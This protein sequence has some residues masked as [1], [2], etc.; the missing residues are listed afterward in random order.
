L[1]LA[2]LS[3][4]AEAARAAQEIGTLAERIDLLVNNAGGPAS[5]RRTTIDGFEHT[6][7]ANHLGPFLLTGKLLPLLRAAGPGAQVINVSSVAH[8]FVK[9]MVWDD[10]QSERKFDISTAYAQSKLA[11]ILFTRALAQKVAV[12]GIRVNAVH[13]GMVQT[14]FS[15]HGNWLIKTIYALARPFSLTPEQGADT[16]LWLATNPEP[17]TGG[18]FVKRK[19]GPATPAAESAEGADRLWSVS[20]ALLAKVDPS[21]NSSFGVT[22]V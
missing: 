7:A 16:I 18:Y 2:E 10:L 8:R 15:T 6:L 21:L 5:V 20:E 17:G 3:V 12:D 11:N 14:N 13:P 19:P 9:D 22:G 1:V 4:W